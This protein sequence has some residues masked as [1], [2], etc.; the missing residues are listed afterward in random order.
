MDQADQKSSDP[1]ANEIPEDQNSELLLKII[2]TIER[3]NENSKNSPTKNNISNQEIPVLQENNLQ[4]TLELLTKLGSNSEIPSNSSANFQKLV[5]DKLLGQSNGVQ[6]NLSFPNASPDNLSSNL[7]NL[8]LQLLASNNSLQTINQTLLK[9]I[10]ILQNQNNS[11]INNKIGPGLSNNPLIS[12]AAAAAATT[13]PNLNALGQPHL[14]LNYLNMANTAGFTTFGKKYRKSRTVFSEKQLTAL[15]TTFIEKKYLSTLDRVNLAE[16]LN[17]T[18]AQ[19]KTWFQNRRMKWKKQNNIKDGSTPTG[20]RSENEI[21]GVEKQLTNRNLDEDGTAG[22]SNK[23]T[24]SENIDIEKIEDVEIGSQE[25][26]LARLNRMV[27]K[28]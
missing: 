17:L 22:P 9:K 23:N 20:G 21:D 13:T 14:S 3:N 4:Q 24:S 25:D 5:F 11:L 10:A 1:N 28:K 16:H 19:V 18:E 8:P 26:L 15:E 7:P 6:N 27:G 12:A 2:K